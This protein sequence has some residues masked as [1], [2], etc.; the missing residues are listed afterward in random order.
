MD[1]P[2]G[3]YISADGAQAQIQR[4]EVIANNLANVETTGFKREL[5]IVQARYAEAAQQGLATPGSG[6]IDDLGGGVQLQRD[7][8]RL[9][10]RRCNTRATPPTWPFT[11]TASSSSA[12]A[13]KRC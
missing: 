2:H 8:D 6:S 3:L 7:E 10:R 12:R 4:M 13:T 5:G 9:L 11:A 1:M